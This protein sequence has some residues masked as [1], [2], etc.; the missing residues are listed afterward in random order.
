LTELTNRNLRKKTTKETL[1]QSQA[2]CAELTKLAD[3]RAQKIQILTKLANAWKDKIEK[4]ETAWKEE[5][6][7]NKGK[8]EKQAQKMQTIRK[9]NEELQGALQKEKGKRA[10]AN[11]E[12]QAIRQKVVGLVQKNTEL[13]HQYDQVLL[14]LT[15]M[16]ACKK[17]LNMR[18]QVAPIGLKVFRSHTEQKVMEQGL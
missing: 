2:K 6:D 1:K 3:T 18:V 17:R 7:K 12:V 16:K 13:H 10:R 8:T 14:R 4:H 5:E 15:I 9:T 11:E